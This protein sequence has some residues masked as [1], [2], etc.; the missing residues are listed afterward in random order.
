[1]VHWRP[2][3][4]HALS[5]PPVSLSSTSLH[6]L[7]PPPHETG[8]WGEG[9]LRVCGPM[10]P[11][12]GST[13]PVICRVAPSHTMMVGITRGMISPPEAVEFSKLSFGGETVGRG[14]M[15][16]TPRGKRS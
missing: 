12:C 16:E 3:G 14:P 9:F 15:P 7:T 11:A 6:V 8:T 2:A 5:L 4:G 10:V 1:M 13:S